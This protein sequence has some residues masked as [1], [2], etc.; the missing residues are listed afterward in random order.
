MHMQEAFEGMDVKKV[1]L[2]IT[3]KL[4][5]T[6]L[7]LPIHPYM[8]DEEIEKVCEAVTAFTKR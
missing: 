4:C 3:P 5:D 8:S 6:V 7:S 1:E 2:D